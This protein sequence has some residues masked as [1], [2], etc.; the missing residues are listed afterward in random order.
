MNRLPFL[1]LSFGALAVSLPGKSPD[2]IESPAPPTGSVVV[3]EFT[4]FEDVIYGR[5]FGT[6]LTLDV[7]QP[8]NPNGFGVIYIVSGGWTSS[9]ANIKPEKHAELLRR[10]YTVFNVCHGSQPKFTIPEMIQ[11]IHRAVRF[12]RTRAD[13][14]GVDPDKLGLTG[15]SAGG[16]LSLC[17]GT[18][19]GA[20]RTTS[21][22][23]DQAS[24]AV[25]A[26][27]VFYPPTD[28]LNYG[29]PGVDGTGV[30]Q[31]R[32]YAAPF[33]SEAHTPEGRE[34]LGR[35]ISPIYFITSS[36]PPTLIIHGEKDDTVPL[37]QAE[38]FV[39]R[40]KA[41][42]TTAELVVKPGAGHGWKDI[43]PDYERMADW[44]DLHLRGLK[45]P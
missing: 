23:V 37:Q 38:S 5:K 41:A 3:P 43:A 18:M 39:A 4:R 7:I 36:T 24:S 33:G 45:G 20:G 26:V 31:L 19:G 17:I 21:D 35:D 8:K 34:R 13:K 42:G 30:G 6:A 40:A 28:F 14:W 11:D 2:I 29:R 44:F 25:Q 15:G 12:V 16:H 22:P 1:L 9:H 27:A 32:A 10:G